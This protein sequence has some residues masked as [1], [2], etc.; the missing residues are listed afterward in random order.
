MAATKE[1]MDGFESLCVHLNGSLVRLDLKSYKHNP[2]S[3]IPPFTPSATVAVNYSDIGHLDDRDPI[4]VVRF[5]IYWAAT[6]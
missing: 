2:S 6:A 5:E 1:R 3:A 4:A